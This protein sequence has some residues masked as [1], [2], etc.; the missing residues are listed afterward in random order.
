MPPEEILF[1]PAPKNATQ[2]MYPP[3]GDI[4]GKYKFLMCKLLLFYCR[5]QSCFELR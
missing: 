4:E 5:L 2:R 1:F 3:V